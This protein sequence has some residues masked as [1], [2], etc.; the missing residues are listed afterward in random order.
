MQNT[1]KHSM[2]KAHQKQTLRIKNIQTSFSGKHNE[3]ITPE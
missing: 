1:A 2:Q 3:P